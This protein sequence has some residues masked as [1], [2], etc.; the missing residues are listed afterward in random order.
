MNKKYKILVVDDNK[1]LTDIISKKFK[2]AGMEVE[3][4]NVPDKDFVT[5]VVKI[6]PDLI[7]LD[8]LMP[9]ISGYEAIT[10]LK[11][12]SRT[13]DI[14]VIFLSNFSQ[15]EEINKGISLGAVDFLVTANVMPDDL[16]KCYVDYLNNPK[17]Y[18][19]R[20]PV[21]IEAGKMKFSG[22]TSE[23]IGKNLE[24][25]IQRRFV[26]LGI[27]KETTASKINKQKEKIKIPITGLGSFIGGVAKFLLFV[28]FIILGIWLVVALGPLWIIALVLLGIFFFK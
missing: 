24:S 16:V 22:K 14:P 9:K 20:Y 8:I 2:N 6:K 5:H 26:E 7:S 3:V 15:N 17:D 1:F 23:E 28:L 21:Y 25:F 27:A 12:D 13:R 4:I 19:K 10:M 11:A 18:I